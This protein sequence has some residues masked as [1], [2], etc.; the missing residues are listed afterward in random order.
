MGQTN[1]GAGL[2]VIAVG[3]ARLADIGLMCIITVQL[4]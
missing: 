4:I 3:G 1:S 2:V